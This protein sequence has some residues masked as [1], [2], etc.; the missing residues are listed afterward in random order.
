MSQ[1]FEYFSLLF[2]FFYISGMSL[3]ACE[4]EREHSVWKSWKCLKNQFLVWL[5]FYIL[6]TVFENH[7]KCQRNGIFPWFFFSVESSVAARLVSTSR[8]PG[9]STILRFSFL[10][11]KKSRSR[12]STFRAKWTFFGIKMMKVYSFQ[13]N[14]KHFAFWSTK[15]YHLKKSRNCNLSENFEKSKILLLPY[16]YNEKFSR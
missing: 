8:F 7:R 5:T 10:A 9:I 4:L 6:H 15:N 16:V 13:K 14:M 11:S 2:A 1:Y 12:V 3:I